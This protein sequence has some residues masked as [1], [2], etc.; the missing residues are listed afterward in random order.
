MATQLGYG[1]R[2]TAAMR[3][4]RR[5]IPW[6]IAR[7]PPTNSPQSFHRVRPT[8]GYPHWSTKPAAGENPRWPPASLCF[9]SLFC[10]RRR[11]TL[12]KREWVIAHGI[13]SPGVGVT[14]PAEVGA[15]WCVIF[16]EFMRPQRRG[17]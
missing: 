15:G 1:N 16:A 6:A 3:S 13:Y 14:T 8:S 4:D 11:S 12:G 7:L 5:E 9:L 2:R 17:P 10:G